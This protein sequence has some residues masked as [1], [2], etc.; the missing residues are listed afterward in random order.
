MIYIYTNHLHSEFRLPSRKNASKECLKYCIK[1]E[2]SMKFIY[3]QI[4]T[5]FLASSAILPDT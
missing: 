3:L 5:L 2:L 1:N 4:S